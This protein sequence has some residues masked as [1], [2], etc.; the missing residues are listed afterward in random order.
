M[1]I[2]QNPINKMVQQKKKKRLM[3]FYERKLCML[4]VPN[5]HGLHLIKKRNDTK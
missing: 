3:C 2:S 5:L 4:V 1:K